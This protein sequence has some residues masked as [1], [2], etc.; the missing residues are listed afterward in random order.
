MPKRRQ[1]KRKRTPTT[2]PPPPRSSGD[3]PEFDASAV[4]P[5]TAVVAGWD[6]PTILAH[7]VVSFC[8]SSHSDSTKTTAAATTTTTT[9]IQVAG[10]GTLISRGVF[11]SGAEIEKKISES[12]GEGTEVAVFTDVELKKKLKQDCTKFPRTLYV[13]IDATAEQCKEL[14]NWGPLRDFRRYQRGRLRPVTSVTSISK[15]MFGQF[16]P[17]PRAIG[18]LRSLRTLNLSGRRVDGCIPSEIGRLPLLKVLNLSRC[19]LTGRIPTE[20]GNLHNVQNLDLSGNNIGGPIPTELGKLSRLTSI[21]LG[22]LASTPES[23]RLTGPIP[24]ELGLLSRLEGLAMYFT[25]LTGPVPTEL[26]PL[27]YLRE[28]TVYGCQLTGPTPPQ[29]YNFVSVQV[30]HTPCRQHWL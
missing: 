30:I 19:K 5:L 12:L 22:G 16:C 17:I 27:R 18:I 9:T 4:G 11:S 10:S 3:C 7:K 15:V 8:C 28:F 13:R 26:G 23:A 6:L 2:S 29:W 24:T 20:I 1:R 25:N 21:K 14:T